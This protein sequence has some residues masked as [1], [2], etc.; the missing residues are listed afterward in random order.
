MRT[1]SSEDHH[2]RE[3]LRRWT[4][5]VM[6]K[7]LSASDE[8]GVI[9]MSTSL[10]AWADRWRP[11]AATDNV[12]GEDRRHISTPTGKCALRTPTQSFIFLLS[13]NESHK[14]LHIPWVQNSPPNF[15]SKKITPKIPLGDVLRSLRKSFDFYDM[16]EFTSENINS[17]LESHSAYSQRILFQPGIGSVFKSQN[18]KIGLSSNY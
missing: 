5:E 7:G 13:F 3:K 8:W 15:V 14:K 12:G 9:A 16:T 18:Y 11:P 1:N 6:M 2:R 10:A 4:A 17:R